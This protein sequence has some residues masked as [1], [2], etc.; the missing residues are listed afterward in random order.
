[1]KQRTPKQD[2]QNL[3]EQAGFSKSNPY[4]IVQQGKV[5]DL[6]TMSEEARLRLLMEVAGTTVY[7]QK[8]AESKTKMN[9]NR[10]S[11]DKI[12]DILGDIQARLEEL[13]AEKEELTQY[14]ALDRQRRAVQYSLYDKEGER[15]RIELERLEEERAAHMQYFQELNNE[16]VQVHYKIREKEALARERTTARQRNQRFTRNHQEDLRAVLQDIAKKELALQE[17]R[18]ALQSEMADQKT[19]QRQLQLLEGEIAAAEQNLHQNI[20]PKWNQAAEILEASKT[21]KAAVDQKVKG[22]VQ[23][24][25]WGRAFATVQERDAHLQNQISEKEAQRQQQDEELKQEQE[26]LAHLRRSLQ[27]MDTKKTALAAEVTKCQ[28]DHEAVSKTLEEKSRARTERQEER[29]KIWRQRDLFHD[30]VRD[31]RNAFNR[32]KDDLRKT[33]PRNTALGLEALSNIVEQEGL[34]HGEQYFGPVMGT[35][36]LRDPKYQTA[37]EVAAQNSLFH[38]IVDNDETASRLMR[39]LEEGRL[40]RVTFLPLEQ[41]RVERSDLPTNNADVK[42]LLEHCLEYDPRVER[43]L[44]LVFG[45]KL[46]CR[47]LEVATDWSTKLGVDGITLD[48]DLCSRKGSMTGGFVDTSK[49]RLRAHYAMQEARKQLHESEEKNR[50]IADQVKTAEQQVTSLMEEVN[51]L[52]EKHA[53]LANMLAQKDAD[54]ERM[55]QRKVQAAK[56]IETLEKTTLPPLQR[57]LATTEKDIE[58]LQQEIGTELVETLSEADRT[59]FEQLKASQVDLENTIKHQSE[60]VSKLA[61]ERQKLQSILHDNLYKRRRELTPGSKRGGDATDRTGR[62][63]F[64]TSI[65]QKKDELE[66]LE[67]ELEEAK[68]NKTSIQEQFEKTRTEDEKLRGEE[69]KVQNDLEKLLAQ[70]EEYRKK[71]EAADQTTEKLLGKVR[72]SVFLYCFWYQLSLE[73]LTFPSFFLSTAWQCPQQARDLPAQNPRD[74]IS[75]SSG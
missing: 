63:S 15:A 9:E 70:D 42:P 66:E 61:I 30:Q 20:V 7:D 69:A 26:R 32:A 59:L 12:S 41:L 45:K 10:S 60:T 22:F 27:E 72:E 71:S 21:E 46:L 58:R 19:A 74:R 51:R 23:K 64:A 25:G 33:T 40:G 62:P 24:Q 29:K 75:P 39:R 38:V 17:L 54:L 16:I 49:S 8:K 44:R 67:R 3:L 34:R 52:G 47:S 37:V 11:I 53:R 68:R 31:A 4:Y 6:C 48:G 65:D 57:N 73:P 43:A 28:N 14:Q 13:Q 56:S 55:E 1:M 2:V 35:F 50:E 36:T 5:Q 18:E